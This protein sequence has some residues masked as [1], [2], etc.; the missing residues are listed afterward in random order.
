MLADEA[1]IS[2]V[3]ILAAGC[4][5]S[6][7]DGGKIIFAGNGGSF[8]DAQHLSAEFVSRFMF[9][10]APLASM[11]LGANNSAISAIGNDYGYDQVF[12]RELEGVARSADVFIPISTSGN[13]PNILAAVLRAK[14]L[15][16]AVTGFTGSG[17]G[18][19]AASCNCI[20]V[21]SA[22]TARIQECHIM[23]GHIVCGLVEQAIFSGKEK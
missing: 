13:S 19:L 10:R 21:P 6:L 15:G 22:D 14:D 18:K 9:D 17:G 1:L 3:E 20:C 16:V 11:V 7:Q 2:Q 8:A 5:R 23:L 12:A 4:V